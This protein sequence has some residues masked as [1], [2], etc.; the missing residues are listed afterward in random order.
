[1]SRNKMLPDKAW[2]DYAEA[3]RESTALANKIE[4]ELWH[5]GHLTLIW[6]KLR[7]I[8]RYMTDDGE[9]TA[10]TW[11]AMTEEDAPTKFTVLLPKGESLT[12][13]MEDC[14]FMETD[15]G[16]RLINRVIN[17]AL[18]GL[19]VLLIMAL[20]GVVGD[21]PDF[22]TWYWGGA[23]G[24]V[25]GLVATIVLYNKVS[26]CKRV[27]LECAYPDLE[28]GDHHVCVVCHSKAGTVVQQLSAYERLKDTFETAILGLRDQLNKRRAFLEDQVYRYQAELNEIESDEVD[29]LATR[30]NRKLRT[31]H[32]T[33]SDR[34]PVSWMA[35]LMVLMLFCGLGLGWYL[36][37]GV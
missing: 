37:G 26:T 12:S 25:G 4:V 23:F 19:N 8:A 1:M 5:N 17:M 20:I 35:V 22:G 11:E 3:N 24:F 29:E 36:L 14:K 21:T 32:T 10:E 30:L 28:V 27:T 33:F 31:G 7:K 13:H 2:E 34:F 18:L 9:A 16:A 15:F 6:S